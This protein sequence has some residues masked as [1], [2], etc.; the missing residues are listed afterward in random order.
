[1]VRIKIRIKKAKERN[2]KRRRKTNFITIVKIIRDF[3]KIDKRK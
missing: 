1:M 2:I 3:W